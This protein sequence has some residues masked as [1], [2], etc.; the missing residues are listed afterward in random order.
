MGKF[1]ICA[2][3]QSLINFTP[4]NMMS[5]DIMSCLKQMNP[6]C[7]NEQETDRFFKDFAI[8]SFVI[9]HQ[10]D[11]TNFDSAPMKTKEVNLGVIQLNTQLLTLRQYK[12][13]QNVVEA[14]DT[15]F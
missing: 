14:I 6:N 4:T 1:L 9:F 11:F 12:L 13:R 5:F 10:I 7:K 15:Y 8:Q 3:N 2:E